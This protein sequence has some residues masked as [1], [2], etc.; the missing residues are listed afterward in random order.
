MPRRPSL[1][2]ADPADDQ[3]E[4]RRRGPFARSWGAKGASRHAAQPGEPQEHDKAHDEQNP[5]GKH[6]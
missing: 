5:D 1:E 2:D 3:R 4:N 6:S